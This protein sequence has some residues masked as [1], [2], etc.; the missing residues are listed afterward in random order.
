MYCWNIAARIVL[1]KM[2][3]IGGTTRDAPVVANRR[4]PIWAAPI[5]PARCHERWPRCLESEVRRLFIRP[6]KA[7][8]GSR[9]LCGSRIYIHGGARLNNTARSLR[10]AG[11]SPLGLRPSHVLP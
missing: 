6:Y 3:H 9:A 11:G 1:A 2:R 4:R 10:L 7:K 5:C 8:E